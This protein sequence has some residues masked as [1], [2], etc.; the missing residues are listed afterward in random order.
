[1]CA[2]YKAMI[3]C[4]D[5]YSGTYRS[6]L[7]FKN[8]LSRLVWGVVWCLLFRPSPRPCFGW[9]RFLL[10]VFGA[11]LATTAAVYPSAKIWAPWNLE[12]GER[13]VLGDY[14]D[15]YSVDR[16]FIEADVTVSQYAYLCCASHDIESPN[17]DLVHQPIY[18]NRGSWV[19]AA[20][21][22]GMGVTVGEG[23]VVAARS[24]VVKN[25]EPYTV[26]GGNPAKLIKER[27]AEWVERKTDG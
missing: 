27:R 18:L 3:E 1:M 7:S 24:V 10:K 21:F 5:F 4:Q 19:F 2:I 8:K 15:C 20:A 9:R 23:A 13:S 12:M 6:E 14:V 16:V 25:V 22:V 26:I 11:K 17:R